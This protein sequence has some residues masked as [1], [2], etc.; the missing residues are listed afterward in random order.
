MVTK[1]EVTNES[2]NEGVILDYDDST[3]L[4]DDG[5]IDWGTAT[6]TH[7][8]YEFP[9]QIG[10]EILSTNV[11]TRSISILGYIIP[12]DF[13]YYGMTM[14]QIWEKSV[15][16]INEKKMLLARIF[17]PLD[18]VKLKMGKYYIEGRASQSIAF[19]K[20]YS[21]NNEVMCE[22][23][24]SIL[25]SNPM[26]KYDEV[27]TTTLAGVEPR[28]H[29]PLVF[30]TKKV[31]G[32][33]TEIG[34]I[35]G[36]RLGYKSI[37]VSNPGSIEVGAKF[38]LEAQGEVINPVVANSRT[39]EQFKIAKKMA[40]DEKIIITTNEGRRSVIGIVEGEEKNYFKY[41]SMGSK[42]L[43]LKPGNNLFTYA[44]D[45]ET[46]NLLDVRVEV[47]PEYF[48]FPEQ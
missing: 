48:A 10:K 35:F 25:C 47:K 42:Y 6:A 44:A 15:A 21:Q 32:V 7:N 9:N 40:K 38:I 19:G 13:E 29:F 31:E 12:D 34:V 36:I 11:E 33:K 8:T 26:F 27:L 4:I 3:F 39:G 28:F 24:V 45:D 18:V 5:S 23:T 16:N 1:V 14:K 20:T 37:R 41:V 46:W 22:F 17:N 30:K 43:M 2:I